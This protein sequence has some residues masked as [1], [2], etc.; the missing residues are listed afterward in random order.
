MLSLHATV[1]IIAMPKFR[2]FLIDDSGATALEYG[3]LAGLIGL[4][5]VAALGDLVTRIE[6][7]FAYLG[8]VLNGVMP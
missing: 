5:I 2:S 3:L 6:A 8:S 7:A 1:W 4:V